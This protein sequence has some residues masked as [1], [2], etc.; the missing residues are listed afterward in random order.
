MAFVLCVM[1]GVAVVLTILAWQT[2]YEMDERLTWANCAMTV[3]L[4][5]GALGVL[6]GFAYLMAAS[7][8]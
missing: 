8:G 3:T 6:L 7:G 1:L 4:L 2:D 5:T